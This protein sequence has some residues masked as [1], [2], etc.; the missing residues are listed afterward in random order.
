M[1]DGMWKRLLGIA[2]A[3]VKQDRRRRLSVAD[4]SSRLEGELDEL[5]LG[6]LVQVQEPVGRGVHRVYVG[7]KRGEIW[8]QPL[9]GLHWLLRHHHGQV[10]LVPHLYCMYHT[11]TS[12]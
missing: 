3:L 4:A 10:F 1:P 2:L 7:H 8:T 5:D 9:A 12:I 6:A 11:F